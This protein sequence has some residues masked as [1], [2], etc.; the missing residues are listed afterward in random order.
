LNKLLHNLA[1]NLN[2]LY[3]NPPTSQC[4][5]GFKSPHAEGLIY[6]TAWNGKI[7]STLHVFCTTYCYFRTDS[8]TSA[9]L[10]DT[11]PY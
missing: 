7:H 5:L 4:E 3:K 1:P 8:P 2:T 9:L 6:E 11:I 10:A